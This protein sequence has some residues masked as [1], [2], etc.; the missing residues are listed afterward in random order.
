MNDLADK[1]MQNHAST[2]LSRKGYMVYKYIPYGPLHEVIPYLLRRA[3]ENKS[4]LGATN[5]LGFDDRQLIQMELKR[6]F[7][8]LF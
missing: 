4:V 1:G 5:R 3:Q 2:V 7:W 8:N 6:R